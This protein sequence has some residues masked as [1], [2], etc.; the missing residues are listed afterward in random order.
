MPRRPRTSPRRAP[1]QKRAADTVGV[2]LDATEIVFAKHG[3]HATTTNRIAAAAG[4]SIGTLYHYF[5]STEALIEA[6]V[7]RMWRTELEALQSRAML[8]IEAPLDHAV[9]EIV[10]A[11]VECMAA[12]QALYKRWYGEA[13]HLGQLGHGLEMSDA[14]IAMLRAALER[15]REEVRPENLQFAAD[16]AVKTALAVVRTGARDYAPETKNGELARELSTMI[17]R[18]LMR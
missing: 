4:V 1:R 17:S 7:H 5:P 3:F 14:A 18:Y 10:G 16:L 6:V 9:R 11:L 13:S 8:L 2:L 12:K 15:R